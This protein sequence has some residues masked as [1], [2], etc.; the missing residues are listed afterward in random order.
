MKQFIIEI[1]QMNLLQQLIIGFWL[2]CLS[3]FTISSFMCIVSIVKHY[4]TNL[5]LTLKK[6]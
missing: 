6:V 2:V 1:G 5:F 3:L 4:V